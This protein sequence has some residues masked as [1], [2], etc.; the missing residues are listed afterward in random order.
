MLLSVTLNLLGCS[1]SHTATCRQILILDE[2]FRIFFNNL[3]Q[4]R[5]QTSSISEDW[6]LTTRWHL[7]KSGPAAHHLWGKETIFLDLVCGNRSS[8]FKDLKAERHTDASEARSSGLG[9]PAETQQHQS[10]PEPG[11]TQS[12]Q[13][14]QVHTDCQLRSRTNG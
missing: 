4:N 7:S 10:G 8:L 2:V 12:S 3:R 11:Q 1:W 9:S 13:D 5:K 6:K 14:L